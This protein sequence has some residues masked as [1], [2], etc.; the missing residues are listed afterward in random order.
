MKV[1][2]RNKM[3]CSAAHN[4]RDFEIDKASHIDIARSIE[5]VYGNIY[6]DENLK[7]KDLEARYYKEH[8]SARLDEINKKAIKNHHSN[9]VQNMTK[10]MSNHGPEE[11]L[12]QI[13]GKNDYIDPDLFKSCVQDFLKEMEK[14][15]EHCHILD[16]AIHFDEKTPHAHIR[17]V[18]D[19]TNESGNLDVSK[20][21]ALRALGIDVPYQDQPEGRFNCRSITFDKMC[22]DTWTKIAEEHGFVIEK[23]T[24]RQFNP[25]RED[26]NIVQ[27]K[28][29]MA[30]EDLKLSQERMAA[31]QE[32][33]REY[34]EK[35]V[36]FEK[37]KKE[38]EEKEEEQ[39]KEEARIKQ[40]AAELSA[41]IVELKQ[42]I[43]S[44]EDKVSERELALKRLQNAKKKELAEIGKLP[45]K[46]Q[47]NIEKETGEKLDKE[48]DME[49]GA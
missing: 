34:N 16:Y 49:I 32:L 30:E 7:F 18:W 23:T 31:I 1:V 47:K 3:G 38:L 14:Y 25:D 43:A 21:K 26:M 10:Y 4:D 39:K 24:E 45:K 19:Y 20:D 48:R 33:E 12:L 13:G 9:L 42:E 22:R 11:L 17:K 46:S 44:L 6:N 28:Q 40:R 36:D 5:N 27:F 2:A 41:Q 29:E 37:R 15:S 35:V 8:Y